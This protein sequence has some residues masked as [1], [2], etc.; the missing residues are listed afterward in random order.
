VTLLVQVHAA[1]MGS[2]PGMVHQSCSKYTWRSC[3]INILVPWRSFYPRTDHATFLS[4]LYVYPTNC[5]LWHANT[6]TIHQRIFCPPP[7]WCGHFFTR[8]M[9]SLSSTCP[10]TS[11]STFY[12]AKYGHFVTWILDTFMMSNR[13]LNEKWKFS[14]IVFGH[15]YDVQF[16]VMRNVGV[17]P[18]AFRTH[19]WWPTVYEVKCGRFVTSFWDTFVMT[20]QLWKCGRFFA[21]FSDIFVMTNWLLKGQ[22]HKVFNMFLVLKTKS[23]LFYWA[24]ILYLKTNSLLFLLGVDALLLLMHLFILYLIHKF[25]SI[26][27]LAKCFRIFT[28]FPNPS[29]W[30]MNQLF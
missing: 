14:H 23:L 8:E 9:T 29:C 6:C 30:S 22:S 18:H 21:C 5:L 19:L 26:L 11:C 15:I 3:S 1:H 2:R 7:V 17:F 13:L 10:V 25:Y 28:D 12:E 20:N 27:P 24:L 16:A 4:T